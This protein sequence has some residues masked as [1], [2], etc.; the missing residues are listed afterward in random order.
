VAENIRETTHKVTKLQHNVD[1]MF[2]VTAVNEV[3]QSQPS[4]VTKYIKVTEPITPEPPVIQ[5][6][7]ADVVS[8][9]GA[10]VTLSCVIGGVPEPEIKWLRDGKPFKA[11]SMSYENRMA[12]YVITQVLLFK[13]KHLFKVQEI[14]T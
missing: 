5:Q 4:A 12:K 14:F 13:I 11:K 9:L 10:S 8:G 3:G 1:Y 7:L 2:R 6:P